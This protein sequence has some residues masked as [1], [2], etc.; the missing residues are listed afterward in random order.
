MS[1]ETAQARLDGAIEM[2]GA[3][4]LTRLCDWGQLNDNDQAQWRAEAFLRSFLQVASR[5]QSVLSAVEGC[6][7]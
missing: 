2:A 1:E 4:L 5:Y 6:R 3:E 7:G